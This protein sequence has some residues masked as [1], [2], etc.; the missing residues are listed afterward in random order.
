MMMLIIETRLQALQQR[1]ESHREQAIRCDKPAR[2]P[3][4]IIATAA[5][6]STEIVVNCRDLPRGDAAAPLS[7]TATQQPFMV[8]S[9]VQV[10]TAPPAQSTV[11]GLLPPQVTLQ[12]VPLSAHVTVQPPPGHWMLQVADSSQVTSQ[13]PPAQSNPQVPC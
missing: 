1:T 5:H 3:F 4:S 6:R 10:P 2:D 8:Q 11:H 13:L 12:V 7:K 9:P